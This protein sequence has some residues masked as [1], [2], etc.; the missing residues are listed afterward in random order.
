MGN[1]NE[2]DVMKNDNKIV[3]DI[4]Q[5]NEKYK[6]QE[7]YRDVVNRKEHPVSMSWIMAFIEKWI[8]WAR[9]DE[10]ALNP[11]YFV[12]YAGLPWKTLMTWCEK[13][14]EVQDAYDQVKRFIKLRREQKYIDTNSSALAFMMPHYDEDYKSQ[15]EWR[16]S[17]RNKEL[18]NQ[19]HNI[20]V[21]IPDM[22]KKNE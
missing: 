2:R 17:L 3:K 12:E 5:G 16:S 22:D 11:S 18:E 9:E 13:Y 21:I 4:A 6:V 10:K 20:T 7:F 14:P 8:L 1:Q 15:H 19:K